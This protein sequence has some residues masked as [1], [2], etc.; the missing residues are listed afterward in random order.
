MDTTSHRNDTIGCQNQIFFNSAGCSLMPQIALETMIEYLQSENITGGYE[1]AKQ[2]INE[3]N[4]SNS[5][6]NNKCGSAS[7]CCP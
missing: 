7:P 5:S 1:L 3:N 6:C 2:K 4:S